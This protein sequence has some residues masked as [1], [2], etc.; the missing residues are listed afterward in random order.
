MLEGR[1][2]LRSHQQVLFE[3]NP[4]GKVTSGTFSPTLSASIALARVS[5]TLGRCCEVDIRGKPIAARVVN[6]PFVKQGQ[7]CI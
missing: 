2:V 4:V 3:G 7:A 5:C 1:G 6:Y